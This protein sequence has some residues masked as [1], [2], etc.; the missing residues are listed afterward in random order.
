[1]DD[2]LVFYH[3]N[4]S[5]F[6]YSKPSVYDSLNSSHLFALHRSDNVEKIFIKDLLVRIEL[7]SASRH[8]TNLPTFV[9][10]FLNFKIIT[11]LDCGE[12]WTVCEKNI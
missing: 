10:M 3:L 11:V 5:Y 6:S 2:D 12:L 9:G 4:E 1:M 7:K 8:N